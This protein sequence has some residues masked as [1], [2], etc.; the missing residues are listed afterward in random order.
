MKKVLVVD[1]DHNILKLLELVFVSEGYTVKTAQCC[2]T[3]M[4][5]LSQENFDLV[6]SDISMPGKCGNTLVR[7]IKKVNRLM[8]V[9]AL[10]GDRESACELFDLVLSKPFRR[11]DLVPEI[12]LLLNQDSSAAICA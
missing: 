11:L 8:P 12:K 4:S 1:D 6:L 7:H 3:A 10:T 9:V 5:K 2:Q